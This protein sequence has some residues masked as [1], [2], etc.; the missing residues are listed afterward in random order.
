MRRQRIMLPKGPSKRPGTRKHSLQEEGLLDERSWTIS[1]IGGYLLGNC[2]L[3]GKSHD[4]EE[5]ECQKN[6]A[7]HGTKYG[8][9]GRKPQDMDYAGSFKMHY[10]GKSHVNWRW[11][12]DS[13]NHK[14]QTEHSIYTGWLPLSLKIKEDRA[15]HTPTTARKPSWWPW[16]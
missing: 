10:Q 8:S 1:W 9:A 3:S 6:K 13:F 12:A 16:W 15:G 2:K 5:Y 4:E 7:T 14:G 11:Q